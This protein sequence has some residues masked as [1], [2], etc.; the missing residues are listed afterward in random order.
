MFPRLKRALFAPKCP[1]QRTGKRP[2]GGCRRSVGRLRWS[3]PP[4]LLHFFTKKN[5]FSW[6]LSSQDAVFWQR[7]VGC[8]K[9]CVERRISSSEVGVHNC[10]A[11]LLSSNGLIAWAGNQGFRPCFFLLRRFGAVLL[12]FFYFKTLCV[13]YH[14]IIRKRHF[15]NNHRLKKIS[16]KIS[17]PP[18]RRRNEGGGSAPAACGRL[19]R[20]LSHCDFRQDA[21]QEG[22]SCGSASGCRDEVA[23]STVW[24]NASMSI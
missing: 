23:L 16:K 6:F 1:F 8:Q 10:G 15:N 14:F 11:V 2:D 7:Y 24:Y 3:L 21:R 17:P 9:G 4:F 12:S 13:S 5:K 20:S 18:K 22:Q 19:P